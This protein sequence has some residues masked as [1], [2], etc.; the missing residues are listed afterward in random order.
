M[1]HI[2]PTEDQSEAPRILA[3]VPREKLPSVKTGPVELGPDADAVALL[4]GRRLVTSFHPELSTDPR[5]HEYF[6]QAL[7]LPSLSA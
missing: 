5:I 3:K 2:L 1:H 6:L 7:V 4:Q